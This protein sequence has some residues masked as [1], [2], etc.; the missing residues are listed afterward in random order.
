MGTTIAGNQHIGTNTKKMQYV[1]APGLGGDNLEVELYEQ[2]GI[3]TYQFNPTYDQRDD[4]VLAVE[5][6]Y[7]YRKPTTQ[8]FWDYC[9]YA[10]DF[11][12]YPFLAWYDDTSSDG[13]KWGGII[14]LDS[15]KI[16][17]VGRESGWIHVTLH[18]EEYIWG[19]FTSNGKNFDNTLYIGIYSPLLVLCWDNSVSGSDT[20][21]PY[22]LNW[23]FEEYEDWSVYELMTQ[24]YLED[25]YYYR[26]QINVYPTFYITYRDVTPESFAYS[27]NETS[28][29][30]VTSGIT[31]KGIYKKLLQDIKAAVGTSERKLLVKR[32]GGI[33]AVSFTDLF[34]RRQDYKR[35]FEE[36]EN[37]SSLCNRKHG[38]CKE[39]ADSVIDDDVTDKYLLLMRSAES[40]NL[41]SDSTSKKAQWYR[42]LEIDP[43][44]ESVV[45]RQQILFRALENQIDVSALPFASRL[46]FRTVQT[47]MSFWDLLRGKIQEANNV[48]SFY[49]PI[50][51]EIEMECRI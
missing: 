48:A 46:F 17:L 2:D 38:L 24:G 22:E 13:G 31:K 16:S 35:L 44:I 10:D 4:G 18:V 8:A 30:N 37:L 6:Y 20:I 36:A 40:E 47:V 42:Q 11:Y 34:S 14:S 28:V 32:N 9:Y 49:C 1:W 26:R 5:F 51:T 39:L 41:I 7:Y 21:I 25:C 33:D 50:W 29:M 27:V 23:D 45:E 12:I 43:G 15:Q 19:R 3:F